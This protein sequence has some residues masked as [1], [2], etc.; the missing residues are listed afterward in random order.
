ML[1]RSIGARQVLQNGS[2]RL[3]SEGAVWTLRPEKA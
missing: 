1:Q 3:V 2:G